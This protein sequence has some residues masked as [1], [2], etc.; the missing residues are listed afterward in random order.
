M[1]APSDEPADAP[2]RNAARG[3]LVA[4]V[5]VLGLFA[6]G[7]VVGLAS[8]GSSADVNAGPHVTTT[9]LAPTAAP[10][11]SAGGATGQATVNDACI[12]AVNQAQDA[13]ANVNDL[14]DAA[15]GLNVARLDEIIRSLQPV[16]RQLQADLLACRVVARLPDGSLSSSPVPPRGPTPT[17]PAPGNALPSS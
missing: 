13:Y 4:G 8:S 15:R 6:G 5:F 7:I 16:Q 14:A 17:A 12:R 10:G 1:T 9:T 2:V 3:W 11:S